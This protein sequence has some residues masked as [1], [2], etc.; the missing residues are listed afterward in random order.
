MTTAPQLTTVHVDRWRTRLALVVRS[1]GHVH[2]GPLHAALVSE[3]DRLELLASRFRDDS[4]ISAVNR[5]AGGW[6]DASW[7]F[8]EVLSASLDAAGAT[9]GLVTPL[10]GR[11]V[12]A[13][14]YRTW[15]DAT[16]SVI[17]AEIPEVPDW[18]DIAISPAGD[19]ARVRIPAASQLDLGAVAKGWLADRLAGLVARICEVDVIADMGGDLSIRTTSQPWVVAVEPGPHGRTESLSV[20]SAGLATSGTTLRRWRTAT[21]DTAHHIIDPRTGRSAE[22][23]WSSASVLAADA[24]A[25]N[26]AATASIVLGRE[27]PAWLGRQ[28]LD[29]LLSGPDGQQRVGRWPTPDTDD[30]QE[31]AA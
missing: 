7:D 18:R 27:A 10:V 20:E 8:V 28:G 5:S 25:A 19:H 1:R 2:A 17:P 23:V 12:D 9:H 22:P 26:T 24:T 30:N 14:G 3:V 29:A 15:R 6:C 31:E 4:E 11:Q 21:G 13:A 16:P